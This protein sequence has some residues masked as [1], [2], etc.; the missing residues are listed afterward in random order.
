[1]CRLLDCPAQKLST[2]QLPLALL[3]KQGRIGEAAAMLGRA[4]L[5]APGCAACRA[6]ELP[7]WGGHRLGGCPRLA[8]L[9][10]EARE[11]LR[12]ALQTGLAAKVDAV[13][14][15]WGLDEALHPPESEPDRHACS[16]KC[17]F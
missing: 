14:E 15:M 6:R 5:A 11:Q 16:V 8:A 2:E 12:G 9:P 4:K 7:D 10:E 1:M 13:C 17:H 3:Y